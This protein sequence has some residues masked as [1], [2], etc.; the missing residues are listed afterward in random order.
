MTVRSRLIARVGRRY[1]FPTN[2]LFSQDTIYFKSDTDPVHGI[3]ERPPTARADNASAK[4]V[5][6]DLTNAWRMLRIRNS[7]HDWTYVE[8]GDWWPG[9]NPGNPPVPVFYEL[10]DLATD[11]D[12]LHNLYAATPPDVRADLHNQII[13]YFKCQGTRCP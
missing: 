11:G 7:T 3:I 6:D 10:Y 4:F 9:N 2:L 13:E 12:Q 1:D 8:F 5:Y